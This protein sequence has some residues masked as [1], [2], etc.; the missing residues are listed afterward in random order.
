MELVQG[1]YL[2]HFFENTKLIFDIRFRFEFQM[3]L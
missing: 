1:I 3:K 2:I